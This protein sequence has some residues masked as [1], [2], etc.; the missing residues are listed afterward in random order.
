VKAASLQPELLRAVDWRV[1]LDS[2]GAS[3]ADRA[4]FE[5]WLGED[6]RHTA[7]W[8]QVDAL[9]RAPLAR[10]R[11]V[12]GDRP[13]AAASSVR[14]IAAPTLPRRRLLG[15][16][17]AVAAVTCAGAWTFRA[18]TP[19]GGWLADARSGMGERRRMALADGSQLSLDARSAVDLF[20][21]GAERRLRLRSGQ[22]A[23]DVAPGS[24]PVVVQ[25][26]DGEIRCEGGR[27][28]VAQM[29]RRTRVAVRD[30]SARLLPARAAGERLPGGWETAFDAH[31]LSPA[32]PD[33]E[34]AWAWLEGRLDVRDQPLEEV[35]EALQRY[36]A[37][38]L[39]VS[40]AA[41]GLR[42]FGVFA[43]DDAEQALRG[44][45]AALP[46]RLRR[47]GPWLTLVQAA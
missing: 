27:L 33:A 43:L 8:R 21:D 44:L 39:R 45:A 17:A 23:L 10:I 32:R 3:A 22:V 24:R 9:M 30:G 36:H 25:T 38:L 46:I 40:P 34:A 47:L 4:A 1:R 18:A 12:D 11:Q 2:G 41:A 6:P 29:Q 13:G 28:V 7:A 20:L 19:D 5:A 26:R 14:T 37:G 16:A 31:G 15:K 35:V 42:V